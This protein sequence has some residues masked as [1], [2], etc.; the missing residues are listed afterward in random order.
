[1][2]EGSTAELQGENGLTLA[3]FE[4]LRHLRD[5]PGSRV[6][7]VAATFAA[8][9]GA[10]S[11][12]TDRLEACGWAV[13]AANPHDRRSSLLNLTSAGAALLADAEQTFAAQAAKLVAPIDRNGQLG[14]AADALSTLREALEA[15]GLGTPV[16]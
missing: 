10:I 14:S 8:G 9:V 2:G 1:M 7:D 13:R 16:G 11:K 15:E 3:Q 12:M 6:A 5:H 4:F